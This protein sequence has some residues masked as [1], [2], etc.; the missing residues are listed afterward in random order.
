[1]TTTKDDVTDRR[2]RQLK[3]DLSV[4]L[5]DLVDK[6]EEARQEGFVTQ[7]GISQEGGNGRYVLAQFNITKSW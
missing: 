2:A 6:M 1:M 5:G 7:F 3:A 4:I